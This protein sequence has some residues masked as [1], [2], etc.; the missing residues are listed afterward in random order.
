M[1]ITS[2]NVCFGYDD[3]RILEHV[4]FTVSEGERIGL[5]GG[6]GEGKTTL[7]KL[8]TRQLEPD[9]GKITSKTNL[10]IGYLEQNGGYASGN[11][12]Y[13]EMREVFK[14]ELCAVEKISSLSAQLSDAVFPSRE[15]DVLSAKIESL[16]KFLSARDC[17]DVDVKIKTVLNG[18]GFSSMY[19]RVIDSMSGGEKTRLKLARLLLESP[20]LLILDEPTN[21]LDI[22]TLFWLE[23]YLQSFGGGILDLSF[24]SIIWCLCLMYGKILFFR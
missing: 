19:E 6:N 20:D 9:E 10:K 3:K 14:E 12:V 18:M 13:A 23:E 21:H 4:D 22:S 15:Y 1:L 17:F 5:I 16:N 24:S 8:L 2:E 7:I 11:T